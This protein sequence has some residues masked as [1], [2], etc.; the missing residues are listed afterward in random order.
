MSASSLPITMSRRISHHQTPKTFELPSFTQ[1]L[2]E[3]N[4]L[5][6]IPLGD[7]SPSETS[8]LSHPG[9]QMDETLH[10]GPPVCSGCYLHESNGRYTPSR[11][12]FT[13]VNL[14]NSESSNAHP[15]GISLKALFEGRRCMEFPN[16]VVLPTQPLGLFWLNLNACGMQFWAFLI[17]FNSS[18]VWDCTY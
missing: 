13:P 9:I 2:S 11:V 3:V 4:Q 5:E 15:V 8:P 18:E 10:I 16:A 14:P 7:S 12:L 6:R 17:E 1:L